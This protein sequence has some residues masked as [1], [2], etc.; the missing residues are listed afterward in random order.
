MDA[1]AF[2]DWLC[3]QGYVAAYPSE[4]GR[5][6][7]VRPL[8]FHWTMHVGRI[9]DESGFDRRYCYATLPLA[10]MALGEWKERNFEGEPSGWHRDPFTG[11]RRPDG[12]ATREYI[13]A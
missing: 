12:D 3:Q 9:G 11:R 8:I 4:D 10:L 5:W 13:E 7:G 6:I 2:L 1:D